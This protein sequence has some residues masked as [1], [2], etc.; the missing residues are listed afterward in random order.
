M[1]TA[2]SGM[3]RQANHGG[4]ER[5]GLTRLADKRI[6][7]VSGVMPSTDYSR[8][9][10]GA[11]QRSATRRHLGVA[12]KMRIFSYPWYFADWRSSE[13]V[14]CMTLEQRGLYRELLDHCWEQGSLPNNTKTLRKISHS[15]ELEWRRAWPKVSVQFREECGRLYH[16]K[17][18]ERRP[19]LIDW[20]EGRRKGGLNRHASKVSAVSAKAEAI[21]EAI[22][23]GK[24]ELDLQPYTSPHTYPHTSPL[25]TDTHTHI[26]PSESMLKIEPSKPPIR[27]SSERWRANEDYVRFTVQYQTTGAA[28]IDDDFSEAYEFCWIKL[29]WEQKLARVKALDNHLGEYAANPRFVPKPLAFL[30]KEWKRPVR[31]PEQKQRSGGQGDIDARS[32]AIAERRRAEVLELQGETK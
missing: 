16:L 20:A 22:A 31:P 28:L 8:D 12:D 23:G 15:G 27:V 14:L 2:N 19:Q 10:G 4:G 6:M 9:C 32:E 5:W 11:P 25:P 30:E 13:A 3:D 7:E 18:D 24:A 29:D 21:P 26:E 1:S 17:V